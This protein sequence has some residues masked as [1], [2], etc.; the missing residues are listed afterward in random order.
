MKICKKCIQPDTRPG[1]F[2]DENGVCGACIWNEEKLKINWNERENELQGISNWAKKTS[3]S[4]YDCVVGISGGKD[5]TLQALVARDKLG[6]RCLLVNSEPEGITEIGKHNIE[7]LKNL[8][9][10]VISLRPNPQLMKKLIKRDFYK[11]LNPQKVTEFSL[12]SSAYIISDE[13]NIPLIIQG[14]NAALTLGV[15]NTGLGKGYDALEITESNTLST[16]WQDYLEVNGVKEKDLFMFHFNKKRI[17]EKG[18]KAIWLQYFLKDWSNHNNAKF[19]ENYG[20]KTRSP[21]FNPYAIGTYIT[22]SQLD[23][24]LIQVNQLLKSIKFGFGQCLDHACYDLRDKRIT[25][26]E[27][28]DLV[29]KYDGKCSIKYIKKFCNYIG[30]TIDEFWNTA[31]MFRGS[32]WKKVNG[33]WI[34]TFSDHLN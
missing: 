19:A 14:E 15:S 28:I 4:N 33:L 1:I 34:N 26:K 5:S 32:M 2:F 17:Q 18:F 6:L 12:Y 11:Y 29:I 8:G 20:F 25:R 3:K 13:F 30:I 23:S 24:D 27:A 22:Y 7:N 16:G 21:N 31:N 9:F 10:D